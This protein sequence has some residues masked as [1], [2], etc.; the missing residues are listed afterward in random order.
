MLPYTILYT[1]PIL[2]PIGILLIIFNKQAAALMGRA[3]KNTA[4]DASNPFVY[5]T[6]GVIIILTSIIGFLLFK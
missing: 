6:I 3:F 1:S 4:R 2:I 5:K